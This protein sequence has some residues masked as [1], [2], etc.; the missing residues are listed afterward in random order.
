MSESTFAARQGSLLRAIVDFCKRRFAAGD[1]DERVAEEIARE[2][3]I[4]RDLLRQLVAACRAG[5]AQRVP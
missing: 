5:F 3:G 1:A 4:D 2:T